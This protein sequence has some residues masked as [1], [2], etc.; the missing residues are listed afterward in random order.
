MVKTFYSIKIYVIPSL[1][2]HWLKG[3]VLLLDSSLDIF[4][5]THNKIMK[6]SW[7]TEFMEDEKRKMRRKLNK[8]WPNVMTI[9]PYYYRPILAKYHRAT[10]AAADY[11][12]AIRG[13]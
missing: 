9:K 4:C 3:I 1:V 6:S 11:V 2:F 7:P 8:K 10:R 13:D 12:E 5:Q